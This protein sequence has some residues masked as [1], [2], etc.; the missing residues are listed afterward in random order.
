MAVKAAKVYV[1]ICALCTLQVHNR[2][3]SSSWTFLLSSLCLIYSFPFI[4]SEWKIKLR[5][6]REKNHKVGVWRKQHLLKMGRNVP[7]FLPCK[8][9]WCFPA[10]ENT[11]TCVN[12]YI[13]YVWEK[14]CYPICEICGIYW[15]CSYKPPP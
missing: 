6:Q 1:W 3:F 9:G 11:Y 8:K 7:T 10:G 13:S 5:T 14:L 15:R 12:V 4:S 2:F